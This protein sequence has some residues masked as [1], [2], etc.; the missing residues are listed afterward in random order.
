M[1]VVALVDEPD[2]SRLLR[3][4]QMSFNS[5][6]TKLGPKKAVHFNLREKVSVLLSDLVLNLTQTH[7]KQYD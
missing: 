5:C 3:V 4:V 2:C 7:T 6:W 1:S